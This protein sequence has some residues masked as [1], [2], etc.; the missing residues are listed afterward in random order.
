MSGSGPVD[1]ARRFVD[2]VAWGEHTTVWELLS[3]HARLAVLD[4]AERRGLDPR[5]AARLREGTAADD[6]RDEFLADLVHGLQS[7]LVG[8]DF[9]AVDYAHVGNGATVAG[10]ILVDLLTELPAALGA[11]VSV[12]TV[13][14]VEEDGRCAVVRLDARR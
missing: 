13:E 9:D 1:V 8:F 4:V 7:E 3:S 10:S 11:A 5:R 2:A 6:E 14:L 12:A